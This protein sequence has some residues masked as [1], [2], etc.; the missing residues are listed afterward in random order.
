MSITIAGFTFNPVLVF[1]LLG[2]L[3]I[4]VWRFTEL[5]RSWL[6]RERCVVDD[7]CNRGIGL[8][9]N[10]VLR[11]MRA[12]ANGYTAVCVVKRYISARAS[13]WIDYG[14][15]LAGWERI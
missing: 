2:L 12:N 5:P 6:E 7:S 14:T 1:I 10:V 9:R 15:L 13:G 3:A 11:I 4:F 8:Y